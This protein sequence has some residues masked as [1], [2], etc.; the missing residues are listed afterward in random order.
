MKF[1][2]GKAC[3]FALAFVIQNVWALD[4]PTIAEMH[5][6][7]AVSLGQQKIS[8]LFLKNNLKLLAKDIHVPEAEVFYF[9]NI[10]G[11]P[12]FNYV[13]KIE[14]DEIASVF[15][16]DWVSPE[17]QGKSMYVLTKSRLSSKEFEGFTYSTMEFPIVK[18]GESL[19]VS[20]FPKDLPDEVLQNCNEGRNLISGEAVHC[21]Y[22]NAADIKKHLIDQDR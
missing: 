6:P 1:K 16:Y 5:P 14:G 22:K 17:K 18:D 21:K 4:A 20:F 19:T 7:V 8:I 9:S 11:K 3:F 15:F 12:S 10:S 13:W 2:S